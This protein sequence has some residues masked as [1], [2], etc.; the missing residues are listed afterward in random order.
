MKKNNIFLRF[1]NRLARY[2]SY[3]AFRFKHPSVKMIYPLKIGTFYSQDGQD[4]FLSSLLFNYLNNN[5]NSWVVDIGCNH[6]SHFS[7]SLFFEK[8]FGCRVLAIDPLAEFGKIWARERPAAKF[9]STAVG[10]STAPILLHIPQ[11]NF[12]DNMFATVTGGVSKA[13]GLESLERTVQCKPL[14][15]IL[16]EQGI[17]EVLLMS[18]DVEGVELDVLKSL[19]F[20]LAMIRCMVIENNSTNLYGSNAIRDYLTCRGYIFLARIG[21]LDD[22]FIHQSMISGHPNSLLF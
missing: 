12:S 15:T 11:G 18:I 22:V 3:I 10:S 6:P 8:W 21:F 14:S 13:A 2:L 16:A 9:I 1:Y 5:P 20:D 19:N 17:T 7:N 4:L